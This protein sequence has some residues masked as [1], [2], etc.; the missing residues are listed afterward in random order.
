MIR[1]DYVLVN[2]WHS[3]IAWSLF[4]LGW[5]LEGLTLTD[6]LAEIMFIEGSCC[7][8]NRNKMGFC[9]SCFHGCRKVSLFSKLWTTFIL[10]IWKILV[11]TTLKV[12]WRGCLWELTNLSLYVKYKTDFILHLREKISQVFRN[13]PLQ[14]MR[15][16][17]FHPSL[18]Y[19]VEADNT[20]TLRCHKWILHNSRGETKWVIYNKWENADSSK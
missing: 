12:L 7:W 17:R 9:G 11:Q 15:D 16:R 6:W 3:F 13:I 10:T 2:G 8:L 19:L 14:E 4:L 18:I 20:N 5:L 1:Q